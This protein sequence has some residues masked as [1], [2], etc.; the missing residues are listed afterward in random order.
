MNKTLAVV[1]IC[2]AILL[3]DVSARGRHHRGGNSGHSGR[4]AFK[5]LSDEQRQQC[6]TSCDESCTGQEDRRACMKP[7]IHTCF[8]EAAAAST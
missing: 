7:C 4:A 8:N 3:V 2:F 5:S 1:F 6:K